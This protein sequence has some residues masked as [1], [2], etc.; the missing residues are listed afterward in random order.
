MIQHLFIP[1]VGNEGVR[2]IIGSIPFRYGG[3][4]YEDNRG[5][6]YHT[7]EEAL[8]VGLPILRMRL[9]HEKQERLAKE[10]DD[11]A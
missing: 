7:D 9:E 8:R 4:V 11:G 3:R 10:T 1:S 6:L 5:R 2:T